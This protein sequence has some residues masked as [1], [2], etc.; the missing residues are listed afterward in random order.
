MTLRSDATAQDTQEMADDV[1]PGLT[2]NAQYIKDLSF[3]NPSAIENLL[4]QDE[5]ASTL[6]NI[7]VSC[8]PLQETIFE[9]SLGVKGHVQRSDQTV[10]LVELTYSGVFTL[11]GLPEEMAKFILFVEC[12]RLLFPFARNV[13][14]Q[15]T[16][17]SGFPPL[18]LKPVDFAALLKEKLEEEGGLSDDMIQGNA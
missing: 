6:V 7:E 5:E 17:E 18:Y 2:I 12:P 9:V 8:Q 11:T 13:V 10:Y 1:S 16:Q 4:R 3:E 15:V 14:A